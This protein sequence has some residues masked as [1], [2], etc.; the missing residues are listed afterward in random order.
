[1]RRTL[2]PDERRKKRARSF[3]RLAG[4]MLLPSAL[5]GC[6]SG[7]DARVAVS[8]PASTR[9]SAADFSARD[10][11]GKPVRLSEYLGK[12]AILLNFFATW[13]MPC[14]EEFPHLRA[15]H[16]ANEARGFVVIAVSIDGP[17]TAANVA[18]FAKRTVLPFS[19]LVDA[20]SRISRLYNPSRS[21][22][23]T[24]LIDKDGFIVRVR[25]GYV[26]GDE[27]LLSEDVANVLNQETNR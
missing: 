21:V 24:V 12:K 22:P 19:T 18:G 8:P 2:P 3:G 25:E 17:E 27:K 6:G 10:V 11:D 5:M 20:D 23:L 9:V 13:C 26:S 7:G 4:S 14:V 15:L 1:M 16:T